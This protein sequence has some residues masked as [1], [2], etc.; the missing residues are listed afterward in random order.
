[1]KE[2]VKKTIEG[3]ESQKKIMFFFLLASLLIMSLG[4]LD[5]FVEQKSYFTYMKVSPFS[6]AKL[7]KEYFSEYPFIPIGMFFISLLVWFFHFGNDKRAILVRLEKGKRTLFS[8]FPFLFDGKDSRNSFIRFGMEHAI[9]NG[10]L[11]RKINQEDYIKKVRH[12]NMFVN[13]LSPFEL[14]TTSISKKAKRTSFIQNSFISNDRY[15][16]L[17]RIIEG[18]LSSNIDVVMNIKLED[19]RAI[20][21]LRPMYTK[22]SI[23]N[24]INNYV[25]SETNVNWH[26]T[27]GQAKEKM[28]LMYKDFKKKGIDK[29]AQR[30]KI[31]ALIKSF[32][33]K[34]GM[35]IYKNATRRMIVFSPVAIKEMIITAERDAERYYKNINLFSAKAYEKIHELRAL[36]KD[37][38]LETMKFLVFYKIISNFMGLPSGL[39]TARIQNYD[40]KRV[41]DDVGHFE[42]SLSIRQVK[43]NIN[44]IRGRYDDTFARGYMVFHHEF[45]LNSINSKSMQNLFDNFNPLTTIMDI[46]KDA[47]TSFVGGAR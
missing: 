31:D 23:V 18:Y 8:F 37:D 41:V 1:M 4:T 2:D 21:T 44:D 43:K 36:N 22:E 10:F 13:R 20:G 11:E 47:D 35:Q 45:F 46:D 28:E 9:I 26:V 14:F 15:I 38:M 33:K 7:D 40:L 6:D 12:L 3:N 5:L 19:Y 27:R 29:K 30:A 42:N 17:F 34:D 39:V 16:E 24:L 32:S 25:P